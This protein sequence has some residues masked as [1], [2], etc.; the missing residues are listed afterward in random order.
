[1]KEKREIE[2]LN[3]AEVGFLKL[4]YDRLG[5]LNVC[6]LREAIE[7]GKI[8]GKQMDLKGTLNCE[9]CIQGKMA[10]PMFPKVSKRTTKILD[11]IHTDVYGPMRLLSN[12]GAKYFVTFIN[13]STRWCEVRFVKDKDEVLK[14]FKSYKALMENTRTKIKGI[15]SDTGANTSIKNSRNS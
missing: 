8:S 6:N 2:T 4:W 12:S 3:Q 10:R 11:L 14:E 1:M 5:H 9:I 15:Q 7:K 13:D